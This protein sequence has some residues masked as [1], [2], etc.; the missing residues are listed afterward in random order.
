M[1]VKDF[2]DLEI[3]QLSL[4][5]GKKIYLITRTFPAEEKFGMSDQLRRAVASIGANIAEAFGRFHYR[6][7]LVFL[8][9]A[10]GSIYE[11]IHFVE[12]GFAVGYID[13]AKKDELL[14]ELDKLSVKLNN[15][16]RSIGKR[17]A[18]NK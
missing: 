14:N 15:F 11:T 8:Y 13:Q 2:R 16:I 10:R 6:D 1:F 18:D 12:L 17:G 5:I 7:K 3:Y 9:N 4:E